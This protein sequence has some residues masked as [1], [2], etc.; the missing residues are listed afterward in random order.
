MTLFGKTITIK[1]SAL[2][3]NFK[4][5]VSEGDPEVEFIVEY[6]SRPI[7]EGPYKK[8]GYV[9][10]FK[11]KFGAILSS[12]ETS[13]PLVCSVMDSNGNWSDLISENDQ[14]PPPLSTVKS[15]D[16]HLSDSDPSDKGKE[17]E[18]DLKEKKIRKKPRD[19]KKKV[20]EKNLRFRQGQ[21]QKKKKIRVKSLLI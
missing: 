10:R 11:T 21:I 9:V 4:K 7:K 14:P 19:K 20:K 15:S 2:E 18:D 5:I 13:K 17:K 1:K 16:E 8:H 6:T 12:A 3:P